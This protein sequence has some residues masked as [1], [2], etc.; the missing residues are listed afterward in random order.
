[1]PCEMPDA[2]PARIRSWSK[3]TAFLAAF[4]LVLTLAQVRAQTD[5]ES[6]AV[7]PADFHRRR[8]LFHFR[9]RDLQTALAEFR[10]AVELNPNDAESHDYIGVILGESGMFAQA[11]PEFNRAIEL[12]PRSA[13]SHYHL[14]LALA[15]SGQETAALVEYETSLRL[16]RDFAEALYGISAVC[17]KVGDADGAIAALRRVLA[18]EPQFT[19]ARYNLGLELW[20]RYSHTRRLRRSSELTEALEQ[21]RATANAEPDEPDV[22]LALGQILAE[23]QQTAPAV[24][25]LRRAVTLAP[26]RPDLPYN[27]GLVLRGIDKPGEAESAFR[28]AVRLNPAFSDAHRALG[29]VLRQR[30]DTAAAEA[31]LRE[32]VRIKSDDQ[33]ALYNLGTMLLKENRVEE[34]GNLLAKAVRLNPFQAEFHYT[35]A[36][37]LHRSGRKQ[38]SEQ[39]IDAGK[40]ADLTRENAG[41]AMILVQSAAEHQRQADL[42]SAIRELRQ[43]TVL[44]PEFTEAQYQLAVALKESGAPVAQIKVALQK[45][46]EADPNHAPAHYEMG[47]VD[48]SSGE[49][50]KAL[51]QYVTA[52]Q[53]APGMSEAHRKVA[54]FALKGHDWPTAVEQLQAA[55]VW[56]PLDPD[57]LTKIGLAL[58]KMRRWDEGI[59]ELHE[60]ITVGANSAI[61]H[62]ALGVAL[63][64]RGD[65][66][67]G[68]K[69][70][71]LA[72][73]IQPGLN[74]LP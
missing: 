25:N 30:G 15:R 55:L 43:A 24:E 1:M 73:R 48:E 61:A 40:H 62:Y 28:E 65:N 56:R 71:A 69:Q 53:I 66:D 72:Q 4:F 38:D 59:D 44:S 21:L 49:Q 17:S 7:S 36:Q 8:G 50:E 13:D 2:S 52:T 63:Q 27:L 31:E 3:I 5:I 33:E 39:E 14:G 19:E 26:N 9:Q 16:K 64:A 41:K 29:L 12:N 10:A 67:E 37:A 46:L 6:P 42:A 34:A 23:R 57:L 18:L 20:Q 47:L 32:A 54:E 58:V 68:A 51:S 22:L 74:S 35:L 60:A 45:A 11:M 70:V